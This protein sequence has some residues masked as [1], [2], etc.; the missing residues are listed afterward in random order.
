VPGWASFWAKQNWQE[1]NLEHRSQLTYTIREKKVTKRALI[2]GGAGFIGSHLSEALLERGY[3]VTIIDDL[4][5]G[6]FENIVHL[7]DHPRFSFAIDTIANEAV[8]DRLASECTIIYHLA[9]AVGV[10]LIVERP[11]HTIQANVN[12]TEAVSE[13]RSALSCESADCIHIRGIRQREIK[14]RFEKM[15]MSF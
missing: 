3:Q 13:G 11:V 5:T 8:L 7:V 4:S 1:G 10:K 2:T 14:C 9:A 6:R 12:G 15:T